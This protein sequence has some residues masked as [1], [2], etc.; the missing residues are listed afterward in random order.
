LKHDDIVTKYLKLNISDYRIN[1]V[2]EL[3]S[4]YNIDIKNVTGLIG[5]HCETFNRFLVN[6]YNRWGLEARESIKP[7]LVKHVKDT[8]KSYLRFEY[9]MY[10]RRTWLHVKNAETWY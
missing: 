10:G 8:N 7:I 6:F 2:D 3:V 4:L 5:A 1:S 9:Y